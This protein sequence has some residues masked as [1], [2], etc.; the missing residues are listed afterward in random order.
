MK[1]SKTQ[2]EGVWL[3]EPRAIDDNR[4]FFMEVYLKREFE[5]YGID[6]EFL[7]DNHS[8]T[9]SK[10]TV[11]GMHFQVNPAAQSK[12]IRVIRGEI[13]NAVVDVRQSSPTYGQWMTVAISAESKKQLFVPKGFANGY[14]TLAD[15][16]DISYKVDNYYAPEHDRAFRW[17]DP[18]VGIEWPASDPILSERDRN[19]P[20]LAEVDSNLI[21][22]EK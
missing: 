18:A 17:N 22:E 6:V 7:Q 9:K 5:K 10:G 1:F 12:L 14:C 16:T 20:V 15:D 11:R 3:I 21:Y 8:Y 2:F 19:A 13:L 4:G